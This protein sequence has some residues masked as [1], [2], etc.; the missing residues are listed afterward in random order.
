MGSTP[1]TITRLQ[2]LK[3]SQKGDV[4]GDSITDHA[5]VSALVSHII[6]LT[7]GQFNAKAADVNGDGQVDIT[8]V[9]ALIKMIE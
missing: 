9:T 4:T 3:G 2:L 1:G 6:G 7:P 8:D 5:D